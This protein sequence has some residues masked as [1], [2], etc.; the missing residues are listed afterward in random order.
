MLLNFKIT[1]ETTPSK[2]IL[3][4]DHQK[5]FRSGHMGHALVEYKKDCILSFYSNCSA[6]RNIDCPGHNGFGWMEYKR[7]TDGGI[8]WSEP[9]VLDYTYDAFINQPFTVSCEKAV[10]VKENEIV[11]FGVRNLNPNGW[12]PF[13]SPIVFRS[14]DGGETWSEPV[15]VCSNRG[16]I[17]DAMVCDGIIYFVMV[18]AGGEWKTSTPD[19]HYSFYKSEDGG[20]TFTFVSHVPA[21]ENNAYGDI[22]VME[23]GAFICYIYNLKD[24]YNLNYHIS[25]DK[26]LT[27]TKSGKS[28]LA[29]RIRNPQVARVKGGYILHGRS[30][31]ET[32]ELPFH[33]VLYTS[34]D[35]INWD[36]GTYICMENSGRNAYYSNNLVRDN[37]DGSQRIL[38]QS[39]V[40]YDGPRVNVAHWFLDIE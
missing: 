4:V 3:H 16:R 7:S 22:E 8:T 11:L 31:C 20:K 40:P 37:E 17:Y 23:D 21:V 12:D 30:G 32:F 24:E 25:Y 2:G 6:T 18:D 14:E 33:F 27:W 29:K 13:L 19:D 35:G 26:G 10:S 5:N 9:K 39:S 34:K 15:E 1:P 36:E 38:I 28:F